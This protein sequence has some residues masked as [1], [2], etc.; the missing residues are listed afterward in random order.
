MLEGK[1][2]AVGLVLIAVLLAVTSS[3]GADTR[4]Y[5]PATVRAGGS[6]DSTELYLSYVEVLNHCLFWDEWL[7]CSEFPHARELSDSDCTFVLTAARFMCM[8]IGAPVT[9][10]V[11]V[12]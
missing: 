6:G 10:E 12:P 11:I 8:V 4:A 7:D 1:R 5:L 2:V 3:A 9:E